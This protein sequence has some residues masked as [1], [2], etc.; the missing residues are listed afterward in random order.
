MITK[1]TMLNFLARE[2]GVTIDWEHSDVD[3]HEVYTNEVLEDTLS[4]ED[5]VK[6][7]DRVSG[8][9][10]GVPYNDIISTCSCETCTCDKDDDDEGGCCG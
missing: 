6:F 10:L 4:Y 5:H 9:L 8:I 3:N 2:F 1:E 7:S